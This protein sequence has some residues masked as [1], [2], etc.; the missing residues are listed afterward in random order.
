MLALLIAVLEPMNQMSFVA[1][2][3]GIMLV[4]GAIMLGLN[5]FEAY[6]L[7]TRSFL[8]P[9]AFRISFYMVWHVVAGALGF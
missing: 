7:W 4:S 2:D 5:L 3:R 8:A 6:L 9:L 1:A